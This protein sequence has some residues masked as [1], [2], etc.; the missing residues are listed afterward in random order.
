M[1]KACNSLK[2]ACVNIEQCIAQQVRKDMLEIEDVVQ[3]G[4][5]VPMD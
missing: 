5:V 3:S 2:K 1:I 4:Q